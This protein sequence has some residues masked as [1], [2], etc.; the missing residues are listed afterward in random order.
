VICLGHVTS[1]QTSLI[2]GIMPLLTNE[3][4]HYESRKLDDQYTL[5]TDLCC[6]FPKS[7]H[8]LCVHDERFVRVLDFVDRVF[9]VPVVFDPARP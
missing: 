1:H 5:L 7:R 6:T 8:F 3:T 9:V 2:S 4:L